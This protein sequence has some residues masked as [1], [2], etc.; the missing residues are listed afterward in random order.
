M[1]EEFQCG[2]LFETGLR[3]RLK[4]ILNGK[5]DKVHLRI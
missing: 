4:I 3:M 1:Y 2:S 5:L